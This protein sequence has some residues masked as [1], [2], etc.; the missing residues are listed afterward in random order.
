MRLSIIAAVAENG[1]IGHGG[2][3]PWHLPADLARFK[4]LTTG[5]AIIMGRR[6]F[7][8]IGRALPG[9]RSVVLTG[10]PGYRPAG[11]TVAHSLAEAMDGCAGESEAFVIGGASVYGEAL[12]L[13]ERV[14]I[15]EVGAE[16]EGDTFFPD[17][18]LAG[19]RLVEESEHAADATNAYR[20]RFLVYE[21]G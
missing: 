19:W 6:T 16:V 20:M 8:S 13:A 10:D 14:Y 15:T 7:E 17:T 21:R 5:H 18:G 9:R 2:R 11:V 1:V 4:A 3:L 12:P